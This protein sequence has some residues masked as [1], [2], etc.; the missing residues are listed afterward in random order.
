MPFI[1]AVAA[2]VFHEFIYKKSQDVIY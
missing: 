2:V 1:G